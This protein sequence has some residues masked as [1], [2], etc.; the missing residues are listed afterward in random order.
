MHRRGDCAD[1]GNNIRSQFGPGTAL[2][3]LRS[4]HVFQVTPHIVDRLV[5]RDIDSLVVK[6]SKFIHQIH[7]S[8]FLQEFG[9]VV[10]QPQKVNTFH[11]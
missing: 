5:Y 6:V 10:L 9:L 1:R 2:A 3:M 11:L 4:S 8:T 7:L